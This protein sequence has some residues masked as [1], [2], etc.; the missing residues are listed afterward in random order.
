MRFL[1]VLIALGLIADEWNFCFGFNNRLKRK[2]FWN[3]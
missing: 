2:F 1:L 3:S